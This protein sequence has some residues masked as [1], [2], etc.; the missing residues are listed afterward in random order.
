ME[1]LIRKSNVAATV[2]KKAGSTVIAGTKFPVRSVGFYIPKS[3]CL[4]LEG[5][6]CTEGFKSSNEL[7]NIFS[8]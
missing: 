5:T 2:I 4:P 8:R 1:R 6:K 3:D 7:K